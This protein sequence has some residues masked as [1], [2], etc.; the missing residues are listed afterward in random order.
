M[1][2]MFQGFLITNLIQG[3]VSAMKSRFAGHFKHCQSLVLNLFKKPV[4]F[5]G[6]TFS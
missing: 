3:N 5:L 1:F 2:K 6:I 4:R